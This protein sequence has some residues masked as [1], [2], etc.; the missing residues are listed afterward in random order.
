MKNL[1][2]SIETD[3]NSNPKILA[4]SRQNPIFATLIMLDHGRPPIFF[5][6]CCQGFQDFPSILTRLAI[7]SLQYNL[8]KMCT[9]P[10]PYLTKFQFSMY[11]NKLP[12]FWKHLDHGYHDHARSLQALIRIQIS[13]MLYFPMFFFRLWWVTRVLQRIYVCNLLIQRFQ[14]EINLNAKSHQLPSN[15]IPHSGFRIHHIQSKNIYSCFNS[16]NGCNS[17][18]LPKTKAQAET[19]PR[20]FEH[21]IIVNFFTHFGIIHL[22]QLK[23]CWWKS[24][25]KNSAARFAKNELE[26]RK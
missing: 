21:R 13:V 19:V 26:Y 17:R 3:W 16:K 1:D 7:L 2:Y 10:S 9:R 20:R 12:C 6:E 23:T 14:T 25:L 18:Q 11:F 8:A 15:N 24:W 22:L 4:W 5:Y